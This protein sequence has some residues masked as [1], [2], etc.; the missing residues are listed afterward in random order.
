[1]TDPYQHGVTSQQV[2][3]LRGRIE[4]DSGALQVVATVLG[5]TADIELI[6]EHDDI[7]TAFGTAEPVRYL[8]PRRRL[9]LTVECALDEMTITAAPDGEAPPV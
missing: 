9:R 4:M 1:M 7:I 5:G 6:E 8:N 2:G 3:V